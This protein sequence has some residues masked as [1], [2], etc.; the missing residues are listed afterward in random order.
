[1][2]KLGGVF[3][4]SSPEMEAMADL[5]FFIIIIAVAIFGIISISI[6]YILI[7]FRSQPGVISEPRQDFGS[8][9]VEI[10]WTV[11][12]AL[13]VG[14]FFFSTI[15]T[16]YAVNPPFGDR[17]P[18][19]KII[20]H[21]WWWEINYPKSGVRTANEVHIPIGSKLLVRLESVDVIHDFWVPELAPKIDLV[22]GHINHIWL[23]ASKTGTYLGACAEF[24]GVQHANMRIR[25][26]AETQEDF[27]EWQKE[28]LRVPSMPTTGK[29][30]QGAKL[31]Q[32]K[33]CVN[34]HLTGVGPDLTHLPSRQTLAA[35][36]LVNT[37]E[38]LAKW[39]KNPE[40]FK[41]GSYMPNLKLTDAEVSALVAYLEALK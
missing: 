26:I 20:G 22:P 40:K 12:P 21:Q 34:C 13:I 39:L 27:D 6:V 23:S 38:N 14:V 5:T 29:A 33:A 16:M 1:M 2:D 8:T 32:E 17:E 24:C 10:V 36:A 18:D 37:P 31:F 15:R 25:V 3:N 7:R 41:P 11:I 35:G 30:A 19:I 28:Q 9:R 4:A